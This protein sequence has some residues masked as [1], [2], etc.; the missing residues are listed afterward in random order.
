MHGSNDTIT[1]TRKSKH[2]NA[3]RHFPKKSEVRTIIGANHSQFSSVSDPLPLDS[4]AAITEEQQVQQTAAIVLD[5]LARNV[6]H[7][8][9]SPAP[10]NMVAN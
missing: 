4:A 7:P 6:S 10:E 8:D 2:P 3:T 9:E 5:F 1:T